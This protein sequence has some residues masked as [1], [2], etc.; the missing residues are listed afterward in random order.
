MRF[1]Y[2]PWK[3]KNVAV[4]EF[5]IKTLNIFF[6][7]NF[8]LVFYYLISWL[9][10]I[11]VL[12]KTFNK[13]ICSVSLYFK[14]VFMSLLSVLLTLSWPTTGK[15][16]KCGKC[17]RVITLLGSYR[18]PLRNNPV[19]HDVMGSMLT[20]H[21]MFMSYLCTACV[22]TESL[23]FCYETY[24]HNSQETNWEWSSPVCGSSISTGC[25]CRA[26]AGL[27]PSRGM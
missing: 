18:C 26:R 25:R 2:K 9:V 8:Q 14:A 27:L 4:I 5:P 20:P 16:E 15:C 12:I 17:G 22:P 13:C 11:A 24:L 10:T 3:V 21:G 7:H 19:A 6:Q 1:D 23:W